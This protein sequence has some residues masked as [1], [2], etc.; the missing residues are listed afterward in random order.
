MPAGRRRLFA[1]WRLATVD[2]PAALQAVRQV[3]QQLA[4]QHPELRLGLFQRRDTVAGE[5]TLM[6][7]YASDTGEGVSEA[8][9]QQIEAAVAP[10]VHRWLMGARHVEMFEALDG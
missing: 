5:A 2:L 1:Y 9:Q 7:T 4:R 6:E 8:L 10:A 3:Q